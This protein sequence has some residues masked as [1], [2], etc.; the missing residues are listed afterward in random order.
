MSRYVNPVPQ[1]YLNDGSVA[2]SGKLY[3]YE[4]KDPNTKKDTF[5]DEPETIKNTNPVLLDGEGRCPPIFGTGRYTVVLKSN[6]NIQQWS[7]DDVDLTSV[8]GQFADWS[9]IIT[10]RV[11]DI[12]R[13]SDGKYYSSI[14]SNNLG[15]DPVSS[16]TLW[17]ELSF[18][19]VWNSSATYSQDDI[20]IHDGAFYRSVSDGNIG[21]QPDSSPTN[22]WEDTT[23][24]RNWISTRT[25]FTGNL[26]VHNETIWASTI[27]NNLNS[28][29]GINA[30]WR[31]LS[32][33]KQRIELTGAS[34]TID[35]GFNNTY[36]FSDP[37]TNHILTID[38]QTADE[39]A[40]ET[41][42]ICE[43][44]SVG[45]VTLN[46][47]GTVTATWSFDSSVSIDGYSLNPGET[48]RLLNTDTKDTYVAFPDNGISGKV[49][50]DGGFDASAEIRMSRIGNIVTIT[51]DGILSH[52]S[53]SSV[54]SA[55]GVIPTIYRPDNARANVYHIRSDSVLEVQIFNTGTF[56]VNYR[57]WSG[58][59]FAATSTAS[60]V[61]ITYDVKNS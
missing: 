28:E 17:E 41:K 43:E 57:D 23:E 54:N 2:S 31:D 42:I 9:A 22:V 60:N 10:Y 53:S 30:D 21:N 52:P 35:S 48:V 39:G 37:S 51:S 47:G 20:V 32:S 56:N 58:A 5:S 36:W 19:T 49:N 13:G 14:A 26:V 61:H 55:V 46:L 24:P 29:P 1:Y 50:L 4:N 18:L 12:V 34:S 8:L 3:F 33:S 25:Y 7:R 16:P 40:T 27:D 11:N 44:S 15:N 59:A 38:N 45:V 6:H